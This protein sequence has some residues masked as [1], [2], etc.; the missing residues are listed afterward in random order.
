MTIGWERR[1]AETQKGEADER[2]GISV[3]LVTGLSKTSTI[4]YTMFDYCIIAL[5][6]LLGRGL[7]HSNVEGGEG[8]NG[9]FNM[10]RRMKNEEGE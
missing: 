7:D 1:K 3:P 2:K 10:E 4:Q 6:Y 5:P 8:G 9:P